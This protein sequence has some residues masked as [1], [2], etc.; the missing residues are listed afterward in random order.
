MPWQEDKWGQWVP[1]DELWRRNGPE[2][3]SRVLLASR[4]LP[5]NLNSSREACF[6]HP[7]ER[8]QALPSQAAAYGA[9]W[10]RSLR[11]PATMTPTG[12]LAHLPPPPGLA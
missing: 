2:T 12:S 5:N 7:T 11:N 10:A 6:G 3:R 8:N 9:P 1:V 4:S